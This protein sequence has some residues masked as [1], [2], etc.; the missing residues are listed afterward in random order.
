MRRQGCS[1]A[2][3]LE[4]RPLWDGGSS[5]RRS[6]PSSKRQQRSEAHGVNGVRCMLQP[7]QQPAQERWC[8]PYL[9][10]Y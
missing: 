7:L 1:P 3:A 10:L 2:C 8:V 6:N 5:R 9:P 4:R